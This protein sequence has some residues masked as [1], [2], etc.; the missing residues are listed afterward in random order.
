MHW[1]KQAQNE[2][3]SRM[4]RVVYPAVV[5]AAG[6]AASQALFFLLVYVSN[7]RLHAEMS[8]LDAAGYLI[9]PNEYVL[10]ALNAF[11]P[12]FAGALFFTF[13][14]GTGLSLAAMAGAW[15]YARAFR[16]SRRFVFLLAA[17]WIVAVA[18]V[19]KDGFFAAGSLSFILIPPFVF[20][21]CIRWMPAEARPM[22]RLALAVQVAAVFLVA[23]SWLPK[24][25]NDVFID[26][27]DRLLLSHA[28]GSVVNDFYY[29]YTLYPAKLIKTPSQKLMVPACTGG[30]DDP[31]LR[32]SVKSA[33]MAH[34]WLPVS[35][36]R[37]CAVHVSME[38]GRLLLS[39]PGGALLETT[40]ASFLEAPGR[41]LESFSRLSDAGGIFRK[42]TYVSLFT[43]LP[44]A[45]FILFHGVIIPAL[46]PVRQ[47][48]YRHMLASALCLLIGVAA[49]VVMYT[50]SDASAETPAEI[51][52]ALASGD[53]R[54]QRDALRAIIDHRMDPMR[55][56]ID[57]REAFGGSAALRY[58][59]AASLGWSRHPAAYDRLLEMVDD[60][61]P[62]VACMAY[63]SLGR[64]GDTRAIGEIRD[65]IGE[66]GHWYVQWYAYQSMRRLGW[67]QEQSV[68]NRD[69]SR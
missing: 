58:W 33:L 32:G 60:P 3:D 7:I 45:L 38:E 2:R 68:T 35:E 11:F 24:A 57:G 14:I 23:L 64:L 31:D 63:A 29:R 15:L 54:K 17:L 52:A 4:N 40:P 12:A 56:G 53:W 25:D 59:Y 16:S 69:P 30:I 47:V 1:R 44:L 61:H 42:A 18:A 41:A 67:T 27:R 43:A 48:F 39:G 49:A 34:D 13:T 19:N 46:F 55:Y 22:G 21:L 5:L 10:D 50:G 9:V 65:R 8:T 20:F 37:V 51:R 66:T 6:L 26:I 36:N 28:T 62:N